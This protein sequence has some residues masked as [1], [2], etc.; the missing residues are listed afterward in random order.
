ME[1][2]LK[3]RVG[4]TPQVHIGYLPQK[5]ATNAQNGDF[6]YIIV[7]AL[8][9]SDED[10]KGCGTTV[11]LLFGTQSTDDDGFMD[12]LNVMEDVR[13]ALL[14]KRLLDHRYDMQL[15]YQW[16]LFEEQPS[17][18][19]IGEAMTTWTLPTILREEIPDL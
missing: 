19:W 7:R 17:P 1:L 3:D 4:G 16:Q 11:K 2:I 6:P 15:P 5:T 14:K 9:G 12:V 13:I 10:E 18:E 8:K